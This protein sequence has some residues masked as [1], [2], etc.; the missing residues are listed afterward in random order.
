MVVVKD[1][2]IQSG[3]LGVFLLVVVMA[4]GMVVGIDRQ[5]QFGHVEAIQLKECIYSQT[6]QPNYRGHHSS[7]HVSIFF[8]HGASPFVA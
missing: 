4:V 5:S 2:Q 7:I 3:Q 8:H 1:H 6:H